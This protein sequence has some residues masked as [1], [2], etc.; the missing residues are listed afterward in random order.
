MGVVRDGDSLESLAEGPDDVGI[1]ENFLMACGRLGYSGRETLVAIEL[2]EY[3]AR[4]AL[5]DNP[6]YSIELPGPSLVSPLTL[7]PL[8]IKQR[9]YV[10]NLMISRD[11]PT[12]RVA[13]D[14]PETSTLL[15]KT[16]RQTALKLLEDATAIQCKLANAIETGSLFPCSYFALLTSLFLSQSTCR[17]RIGRD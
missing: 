8:G 6:D 11:L 15:S 3:L 7:A 4:W 2:R 9:A 16:L 13:L 17:R 10:T 14:N 12:L 1:V 5:Q